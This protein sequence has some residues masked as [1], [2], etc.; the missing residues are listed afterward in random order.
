MGI[1]VTIT[2]DESASNAHLQDMVR[3]ELEF[4]LIK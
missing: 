1:N 3:G 4:L 2:I